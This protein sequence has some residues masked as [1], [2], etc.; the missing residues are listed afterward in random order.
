MKKVAYRV[1]PILALAAIVL[2]ACSPA[3]GL[4]ATSWRLETFRSPEGDMTEVLPDSVVTMDFQADQVS[5]ISGC[6]NYSGPYQST[7]ND[8]EIGPLAST[9]QLCAQP[10][11]IMEQEAAYL[12]A[13]ES[14]ARYEI[15][16]DTLELMD[17]RREQLVVFVRATGE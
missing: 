2:A 10:E 13:L 5:G 15:N 16:G 7:G 6:N 11:G 1:I 4:D 8:I 14:V 17:D 3:Q 12:S 9:R